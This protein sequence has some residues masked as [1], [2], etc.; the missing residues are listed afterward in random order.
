VSTKSPRRQSTKTTKT[1]KTTKPTKPTLH[2]DVQGLYLL[3]E[4]AD[5]PQPITY[6]SRRTLTTLLRSPREVVTQRQQCPTCGC[7]R[8]LG[9]D[10]RPPRAVPERPVVIVRPRRRRRPSASRG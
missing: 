2:P 8:L 6:L 3:C 5:C 9:P 7:L 10:L 1:T 4:T